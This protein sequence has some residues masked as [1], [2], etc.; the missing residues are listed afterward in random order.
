MLLLGISR[1]CRSVFFACQSLYGQRS[2]GTEY[3]SKAPRSWVLRTGVVA[4]ASKKLPRTYNPGVK[5]S[6]KAQ[7]LRCA[8]GLLERADW[9]YP[10]YPLPLRIFKIVSF[11][12]YPLPPGFQNRLNFGLTLTPLSGGRKVGVS[13]YGGSER[14]PHAVR[15]TSLTLGR[16]LPE[17]A[18]WTNCWAIQ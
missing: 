8:F 13:Y 12:I 6:P 5:D 11:C 1:F 2:R 14:A 17:D 9:P 18:P 3:S 15:P 4:D 16:I 10:A 7:S